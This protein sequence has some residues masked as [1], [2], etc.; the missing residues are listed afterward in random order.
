MKT[1]TIKKRILKEAR[2]THRPIPPTILLQLRLKGSED[3]RRQRLPHRLLGNIPQLPVLVVEQHDGPAGLD[4]EGA[5]GVQ[6]G[7]PDNVHDAFVGD[8]RLGCDLDDG[9]ADDGC[10]EELLG[11]AFGHRF[12]KRGVCFAIGMD[13]GVRV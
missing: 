2:G 8:G 13:G 7:V 4:V 5:G 10:V 6:D 12:W 11:P 3:R 9:A 1:T